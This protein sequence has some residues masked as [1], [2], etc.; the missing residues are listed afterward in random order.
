MVEIENFHDAALLL[1]HIRDELE[2]VLDAVHPLEIEHHDRWK[3]ATDPATGD[4]IGVAGD[5]FVIYAD[6]A[7]PYFDVLGEIEWMAGDVERRLAKAQSD[8]YDTA[9]GVPTA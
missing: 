5:R 1:R 3:T 4:R 6:A 8:H 9:A 2:R 7:E